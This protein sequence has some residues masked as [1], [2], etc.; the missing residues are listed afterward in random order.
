[1][2]LIPHVTDSTRYMGTNT[3]TRGFPKVHHSGIDTR[4]VLEQI[5]STKK[6]TSN[7]T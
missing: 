4:I 6:D 3:I 2:I 7:R 1:M 5:N